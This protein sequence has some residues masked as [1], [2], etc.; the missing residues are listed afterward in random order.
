MATWNLFVLHNKETKYTKKNVS[1][2]SFKIT[3]KWAL[4]SF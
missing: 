1:F 3:Q 4:S 2:K